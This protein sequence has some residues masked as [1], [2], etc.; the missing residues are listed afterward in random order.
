MFT[1]GLFVVEV[2]GILTGLVGVLLPG[3]TKKNSESLNR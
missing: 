1:D 2:L 3:N